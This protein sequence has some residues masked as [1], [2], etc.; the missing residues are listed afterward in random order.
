MICAG[1]TE[2]DGTAVKG[3][4]KVYETSIKYS[5]KE[6]SILDFSQDAVDI[7]SSKAQNVDVIFAA[8]DE[9]GKLVA[10][11]K[12]NVTLQQGKKINLMSAELISLIPSLY[13]L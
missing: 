4:V 5:A 13:Q 11:T 6:C 9:N 12:K 8:Y 7:L 2:T 10:L 1:I 3:D